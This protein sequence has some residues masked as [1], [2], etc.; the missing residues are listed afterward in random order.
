MTREEFIPIARMLKAV[1]TDKTFLPDE[2]SLTAWFE[3][4]K[5][6]NVNEVKLSAVKYMQ[7]QSYPPHP[8]DLRVSTQISVLTP[9]EAW[10]KVSDAIWGCLSP[11]RAKEEFDLLPEECQKV[12]GSADALYAYTQGE[13]NE[14]VNKALFVKNYK[15]VVE[16]MKADSQLS[17]PV[18]L[19]MSEQKMIERKE[20]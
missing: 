13:W 15:A 2:D 11:K 10:A 6:M 20:E 19:A 3:L 7:T 18:R 16:L 1:Y 12:L 14:G 4:L 8:S 9:D 5:D 17:N